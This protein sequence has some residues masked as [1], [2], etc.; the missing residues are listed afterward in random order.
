MQIFFENYFKLMSKT[1]GDWA[2]FRKVLADGN[3]GKKKHQ[4]PSPGSWCYKRRLVDG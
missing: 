4:P 3:L 2:I 1:G